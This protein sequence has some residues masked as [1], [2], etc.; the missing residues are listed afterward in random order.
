LIEDKFDT[1][2]KLQTVDISGNK[3]TGVPSTLLKMKSITRLVYM[4]RLI[5][6][7]D[8]RWLH[9]PVV[10]DYLGITNR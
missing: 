7:I 8:V 10:G 1:L 2:K 9:G 3:L 6:S 5:S 4:G